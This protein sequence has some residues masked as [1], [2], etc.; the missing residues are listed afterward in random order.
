MRTEMRREFPVPLQLGFDYLA[1]PKR[2]PEWRFGV[3]EL[4][5]PETALWQAAGDK[6]HLAY[7]LLGRRVVSECTIDEIR[8][9]EL[10]RLTARTP[11]VPTLHETWIHAARGEDAF[12][13]NVIQ[14]SEEATTFF[15][16]AI[17]RMLLPRVIE[18]DLERTL[19]NLEDIFA[20]GVPD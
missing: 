12:E 20:V 2:F 3:I 15:G 16:K 1:D 9:Y 13:V 6:V 4:I 8:A 19:D 5:D 17:D 14:E 18:K 11:G 10:V 7:R